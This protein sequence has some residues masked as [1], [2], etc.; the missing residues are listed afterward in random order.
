MTTCDIETSLISYLKSKHYFSKYLHP[1]SEAPE[2]ELEHAGV[3]A[4][5]VLAGGDNE[6]KV[7]F[8]NQK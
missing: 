6:L 4:G 3:V 7:S 5:E 1:P 2:P 8:L